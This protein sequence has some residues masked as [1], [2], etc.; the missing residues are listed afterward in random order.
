MTAS[1]LVLAACALPF[2][3]VAGADLGR[4]PVPAAPCGLPTSDN[5]LIWRHVPGAQ[6]TTVGVDESD[7]YNCRP[8]LETWRAG[9][10]KG[11]GYCSKI[12][13]VHDNLGYVYGVRPSAPLKNVV[14]Q[15][16][17]C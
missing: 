8:T 14:D 10:T 16:G 4:V 13:W 1:T 15:V 5:L 6:D 7:T 11:P 12:A 3:P 9:E 2:A 17:D